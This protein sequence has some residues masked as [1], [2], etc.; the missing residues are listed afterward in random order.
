MQKDKWFEIENQWK[1]VSHPTMFAIYNFKA[2]K[3]CS[4][5]VKGFCLFG[6]G[7]E[8]CEEVRDKNVK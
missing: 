5:K 6:F 1:Y 7:F 8:W 3:S 2:T 4:T